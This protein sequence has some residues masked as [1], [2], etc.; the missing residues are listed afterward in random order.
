MKKTILLVFSLGLMLISCSQKECDKSQCKFT[1]GEDVKIKHKPSHNE[2][3]VTEIGCGCTYT[4]SY[5][6]TFNT[7][8]HRTVTEVEIEHLK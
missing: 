2:A 3:T 5:Y 8:R 6:S 4:V 7:R 1:I